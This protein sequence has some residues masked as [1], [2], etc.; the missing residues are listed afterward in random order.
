M[1]FDQ[2]AESVVVAVLALATVDLNAATLD[3]DG[4]RTSQPVEERRVLG[5]VLE[6]YPHGY[7]L[8]LVFE[9]STNDIILTC[10]DVSCPESHS[11]NSSF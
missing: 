9:D 4:L 8:Q 7:T 5:Y 11:T 10:D 1:L 2:L 3:T 6:R